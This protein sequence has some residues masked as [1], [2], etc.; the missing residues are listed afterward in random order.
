MP[1]TIADFTEQLKLIR[2]LRKDFG[3]DMPIVDTFFDPFQQ[4]LRKAGFS[5]AKLI[6]GNRREALHM[7][8]AITETVCGYLQALKKTGCDAVLY[9]INGA[10]TPAGD[11][12]I[13]DETFKTFLRP[14]DLRVCEAMQ[15]M[16]RILHVHG[17]HI[18]MRRV[19]DYPVE[20]FS[21]SDRLAGNP[22]LG[23]LRK[24]TDKCLMDGINEQKTAERSLPEIR[25]EMQDA[26]RQA[27]KR[28]LMLTPGCTS[29]PQ[30]PEHILR[31][32][33]ETSREFARSA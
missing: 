26:V 4:V 5:T 23:E 33:R 1:P 30:T 19:L 31:C 11:R 28:K 25:A 3:P 20:V 32:V 8:D 15:G 13:D 7:L 22:S 27:G 17:I 10:I 24:M 21:V 6:Y 2:A 16:T 9:S 14:F 18:D 29:A 12:G